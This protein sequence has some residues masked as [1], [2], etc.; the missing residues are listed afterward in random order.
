VSKR[1]RIKNNR[2]KGRIKKTEKSD[3]PFV[4]GFGIFMLL[5]FLWAQFSNN[6]DINESELFIIKG[7]LNSELIQ[8]STGGTQKTYYWVFSIKDQPIDFSIGGVAKWSFDSE[9]FEK[10]ESNQSDIT[11]KVVKKEYAELVKKSN[12]KKIGIKYLSSNNRKYFDL[13]DYNENNKTD[14]KFSYLFLISGIGVL[15]YGWKMKK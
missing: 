9:L 10:I 5:F 14:H 7:K 8:E 3:K 1:K 11:V 15:I 13:K 12:R 4:I 6:G 2:K